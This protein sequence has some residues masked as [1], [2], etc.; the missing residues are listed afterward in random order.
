MSITSYTGKPGAGKSYEVVKNVI[1]P[2]IAAGRRIITNIDGID[3]RK[4]LEY[5]EDHFGPCTGEIVV[6]KE[7]DITSDCFYPSS[8]DDGFSF[9]RPGDLVIIDEA[10]NF[11]RTGQK[12]SDYECKFFRE[13]RHFCDAE[14]RGC[15]IVLISQRFVDIQPFVR[16]V[17]ELCFVMRQLKVFSL[18]NYYTVTVYEGD[19]RHKISGP[20]THKYQ[21]E[22]FELYKSFAVT[23]GMQARVDK[24]QSLFSFR[25]FM[26]LLFLIFFLFGSFKVL[27]SIFSAERYQKSDKRADA[28]SVGTLSSASMPSASPALSRNVPVRPTGVN[29]SKKWRIL[30][31]LGVGTSRHIVVGD[32]DGL[33]RFE[34]PQ[35]FKGNGSTMTGKID[36]ETVTKFT[37]EFE[38]KEDPKGGLNL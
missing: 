12:L 6:C 11:Y 16:G 10:Q 38:K 25:F 4:V 32:K 7:T 20:T 19:L 9:V 24:R 31:T 33:L 36:G 23:G 1:L 15:D 17:V 30:G 5:V 14:G 13:H 18:P 35:N 29:Y 2:A 27:F 34:H 26:L 3:Q 28:S 37:G 21:K 22:I 8:Q